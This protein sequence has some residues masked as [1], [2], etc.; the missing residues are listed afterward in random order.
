MMRVVRVR[1][2]FFLQKRSHT[3]SS[4]YDDGALTHS[5]LSDTTIPKN[6]IIIQPKKKL[7]RN[8]RRKCTTGAN[9]GCAFFF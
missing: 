9:E 5:S 3:S 8:Q 1:F 2:P 6:I 7:T 4:S